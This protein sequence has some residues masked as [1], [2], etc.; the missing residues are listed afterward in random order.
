VSR[1]DDRRGDDLRQGD[2]LQPV[3]VL[4]QRGRVCPLP[5]IALGTAARHHPGAVVE[6]W[7]DDPAAEHD[8]PAWCRMRSAE[9]LLVEPWGEDG[10]T[11]RYVVRIPGD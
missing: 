9:L 5:V 7:A 11:R 3:E 6:V 1:D 2:D 4:D 10:L 8:I